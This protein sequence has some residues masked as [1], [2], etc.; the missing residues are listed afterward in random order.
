MDLLLDQEAFLQANRELQKKYQEMEYLRL[1][2]ENSFA[3]L[4]EEWNS[5]AGKQFF[6][7]FEGELLKNLQKYSLVFEHMGKNLLTA[8]QKYE[9]VFRAA[10][11]AIDGLQY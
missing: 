1:E 2:I 10:D 5:D 7:R 3:Q 4:K 9:E 11:T 8:S 6:D